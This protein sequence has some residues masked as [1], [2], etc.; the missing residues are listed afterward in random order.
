MDS[1][2]PLLLVEG[3][4]DREVIYQF[5]NHHHV[6]NRSAFEV[7][8]AQGDTRVLDLLTVYVDTRKVVGGILD[9]D[10]SHER[11]WVQ[12]CHALRPFG[13]DQLPAELPPGGLVVPSPRIGLARLGIWVMPDNKEPGRL[14]DFL[15]FMAK[16][17]DPAL[18]RARTTVDSLRPDERRFVDDH[19]SKAV[20]H[21][22]LAWQ[23][24]PG[25]PLGLAITRRYVDAECP[26][27]EAFAKWL[28]ELFLPV[29]TA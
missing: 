17:D 2:S 23:E 8:P 25:T 6:D 11:R 29:P 10:E 7:E 27:G 4:S 12:I 22:W 15:M 24:E 5:C 18:L 26:L 9:A 14:E 13:Y 20:I 21:T 1:S 19:R 16:P 3:P 28:R